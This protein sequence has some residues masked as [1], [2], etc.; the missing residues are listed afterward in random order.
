MAKS[1]AIFYFFQGK[2]PGYIGENKP[3]LTT[4][5]G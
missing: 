3:I 5:L 4:W 2:T 1:V